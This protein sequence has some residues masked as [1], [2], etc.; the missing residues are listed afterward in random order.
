MWRWMTPATSTLPTATTT[1][2]AGWIPRELSPLSREPGSEAPAGTAGR[3]SRHNWPFPPVVAADS[4]GNLYIA[5]SSNHRIRRVDSSGTIT[6]VAGGGSADGDNVPAVQARLSRPSGVVLDGAGNLYI[7]DTSNHRIRRVDSS[8]T[9]TTVAGTGERGFGG[10]GGPAVQAQLAVSRWRGGGQRRQPVY[11]ADTLNSR[12]RRVDTKGTIT[13]VAG[14]RGRKLWRGRRPSAPSAVG[15]AHWHRAGRLPAT[16]TSPL[17][18]TSAS[19]GWI[20]RGPSPPSREREP[21]VSTETAVL[22][23]GLNWTTPKA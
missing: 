4:A 1:A 15:A 21:A 18:S 13:T 11:I 10:D 6:T 2:Y 19:A 23:S 8:G 16:F 5:D 9:I 20:A 3:Q 22:Q 14:N 17:F 12:I 7:A